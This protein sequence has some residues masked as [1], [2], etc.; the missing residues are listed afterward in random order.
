MESLLKEYMSRNDVA[1]PNL[2][3]Q[4]GQLAKEIKNRPTGTLSSTTES[5]QWNGKEQCKAATVGVGALNLVGH[6]VCNL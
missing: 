5:T 1:L 4:V 2:E 3:I 6:I